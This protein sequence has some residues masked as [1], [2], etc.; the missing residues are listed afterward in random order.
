[1]YVREGLELVGHEDIEQDLNASRP[2][3][4]RN[5]GHLPTHHPRYIALVCVCMYICMSM[6]EVLQWTT[7]FYHT[8]HQGKE[9]TFS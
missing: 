3:V 6:W 9:V 1:M 2:A 8:F 7:L 5:R 4:S